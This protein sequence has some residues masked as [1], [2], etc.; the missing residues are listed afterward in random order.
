MADKKIRSARASKWVLALVLIIVLSIA[1]S[2]FTSAAKDSGEKG[3]S[4]DDQ[5]EAKENAK[6]LEKEAKENAKALEKEAKENAKE[7]EENNLPAD[8]DQPEDQDSQVPPTP[9]NENLDGLDN[10][11]QDQHEVDDNTVIEQPEEQDNEASEQ[12]GDEAI[13]QPENDASEQPENV[14]DE[15]P[16]DDVADVPPTQPSNQVT[17]AEE[18]QQPA[19]AVENESITVPENEADGA[20][21][22]EEETD[23]ILVSEGS[24]SQPIIETGDDQRGD[25]TQGLEEGMSDQS[26]SDQSQAAAGI[27]DPSAIS[28]S[29]YFSEGFSIMG[30]GFGF[31]V[32][33]QLAQ[34]W[35]QRKYMFQILNLTVSLTNL[36]SPVQSFLGSIN[37]RF[38]LGKIKCRTS[39]TKEEALSFLR[40]CQRLPLNLDGRFW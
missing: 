20:E 26:N 27:T 29:A 37:I 14:V 5:N 16:V 8:N 21:N 17:E 15:C 38:H 28:V 12:D 36:A 24:V 31:I 18:A 34:I 30:A 4:G 19:I 39:Y 9:E 33:F 10:E 40:E 11:P 32:V 35:V 2:P 7:P 13:E 23:P 3:T 1:A 6:A 22:S 25:Q